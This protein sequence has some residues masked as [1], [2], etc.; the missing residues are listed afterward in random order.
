MLLVQH[1]PGVFLLDD[2]RVPASSRLVVVD[3]FRPPPVIFGV[4]DVIIEISWWKEAFGRVDGVVVD[5]EKFGEGGV[6][7]LEVVPDKR[8]LACLFLEAGPS[9]VKRYVEIDEGTFFLGN[10]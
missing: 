1:S 5:K 4:D 10:I 8:H 7:L 3:E 9:C 6:V 2:M